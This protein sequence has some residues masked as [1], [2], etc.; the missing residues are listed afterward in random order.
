M[1]ATTAPLPP[2]TRFFQHLRSSCQWYWGLCW[3]HVVSTDLVHWRKLPP[4]LVPTPDWYD[5]DGAFSGE[6][7]QGGKGPG[8]GTG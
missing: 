8:R 3:D 5:A 7:S 2:S 4:A 1:S 6:W